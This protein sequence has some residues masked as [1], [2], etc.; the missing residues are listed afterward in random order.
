MKTNILTL[1]IVVAFLAVVAVFLR[2]VIGVSRPSWPVINDADKVSILST[3]EKWSH[4]GRNGVIPKN[5]WPLAIASLKPRGVSLNGK[6]ME[7]LISGGGIGPG[8]GYLVSNMPIA[9]DGN[10][11]VRSE[12]PRFHKFIQQN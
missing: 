10:I 12:D 9:D 4:E 6:Q 8:W 1:L 5:Q 11:L 2:P 7:I 3:L